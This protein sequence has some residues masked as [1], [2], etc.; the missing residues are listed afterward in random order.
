MIGSRNRV[1]GLTI[2]LFNAYKYNCGTGPY[3]SDD[4][5][6]LLRLIEAD[7]G[8]LTAPMRWVSNALWRDWIDHGYLPNALLPEMISRPEAILIARRLA[9]SG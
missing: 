9:D 2:V 7:E 8:T 3:T 5:C 1:H 4:I 6:P